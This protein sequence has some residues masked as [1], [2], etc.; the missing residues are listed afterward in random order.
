MA[1]YQDERQ[2]LTYFL[3][4]T[5][6]AASRLT[7]V[8]QPIRF[9]FRTKNFL[10]NFAS[11]SNFLNQVSIHVEDNPSA[12]DVRAPATPSLFATTSNTPYFVGSGASIDI[13]H[14]VEFLNDGLYL[15]VHA[16]NLNGSAE[17]VAVCVT[18][19]K[20]SD[21]KPRR[22]RGRRVNVRI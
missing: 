13:A 5:V 9:P 22:E 8:S 14:E 2:I 15:K 7:L 18:I 20:L 4:G 17:D 6:D 16:N 3:C 19:A 11:G 21:L 1:Q 10:I 12:P